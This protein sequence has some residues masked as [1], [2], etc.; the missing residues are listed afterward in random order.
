MKVANLRRYAFLASTFRNAPGLIRAYRSGEPCAEAVT[1]DGL[2]LAH[3]PGQGGLIG[4]VLELWHEQCYTPDNFYHPAPGDVILDVGAHV[5]LFACWAL[6]RQPGLR[7][8]AIEPCDE[9][10]RCL[11]DNLSMVGHG[12]VTIRQWAIGAAGGRGRIR[13]ATSRSIDHCLVPATGMEPDTVPVVSL[14]EL[15]DLTGANQV[16]FLK[17]DVEGAEHDAFAE[18][19]AATLNRIDRIALEY[20]DNLRPGTLD[21]LR[22]KLSPTHRLRVI[23]TEDRGYGILLAARRLEGAGI[24]VPIADSLLAH[25]GPCS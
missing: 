25:P 16:A 10:F 15:L 9:N 20:H 2:R 19:D 22:R 23:P 13:A 4:T 21:L 12:E 1:R 18:A 3:P 17:M 7:V 24:P 6:R 8:F 14:K 11:R 5:G